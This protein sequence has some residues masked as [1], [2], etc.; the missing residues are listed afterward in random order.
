MSTSAAYVQSPE[1]EEPWLRGQVVLILC[2]LV[3]SGKV[4]TL[5]YDLEVMITIQQST[6]AEQLQHHFPQFH[7]CSQDDLGDRR[8]VEHLAR[9]MLGNGMSICIDRTNFNDS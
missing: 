9:D 5:L 1:I 8:Q 4:S 2:G 7:R 3:G 6:F